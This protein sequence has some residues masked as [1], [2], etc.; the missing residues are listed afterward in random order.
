MFFPI[1]ASAIPR[2]LPWIPV[3]QISPIADNITRGR[4]QASEVHGS[5]FSLHISFQLCFVGIQLHGG[6]RPVIYRPIHPTR[7]AGGRHGARRPCVSFVANYGRFSVWLC[8]NLA[9][10]GPPSAAT[11]FRGHPPRHIFPN[12]DNTT[13]GRRLMAKLA[14]PLFSINLSFQ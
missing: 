4:G 10:T 2:Q 1:S 5:I 3:P 11:G 12:S 13:C 14:D 7:C 9:P 6:F 8:P